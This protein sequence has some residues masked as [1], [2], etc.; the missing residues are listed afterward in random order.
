MYDETQIKIIDS[1]MN[2]I[3]EKGYSATTTKDIAKNAGINECTIFRK[4]SSKKEIILSAMGLPEWNP[5]LSKEDFKACGDA[6]TDLISFAKIYMEKVT[7]Q[8]VKISIG[9]RTPELYDAT[10]PGIMKVPETFKEVL[11][12]YFTHM[13]EEGQLINEDIESMAMM[14]LSMNFGFVFL[15]ASFGRKL[16]KLE[17]SRYIENSVQVFLNGI[18]I[19][20]PEN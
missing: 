15:D 8:M 12:E 5:D 20:Q 18:L 10:A 11:T 3:M 16:T 17:K 13:R 1:T 2:L 6:L 19:N 4:F 7:P 9:L 14:F